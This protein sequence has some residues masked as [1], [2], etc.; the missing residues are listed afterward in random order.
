MEIVPEI[1]A[2][3]AWPI[4]ALVIACIFRRPITELLSR[5]RQIKAKGVELILDRLEKE[6]QLPV[7][8]RAELSGLSAHDIWAL[9]D[10]AT[11]RITAMPIEMKP[12]QRVAARTL[13][14]AG[15]LTL[16][17]EG[18]ARQVEV[19]PLG[20]RILEAAGSLL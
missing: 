2:A 18:A 6:G 8:A 12:A 16:R 13:L 5:V 15:L 14:D 1:L 10:F 7:G 17:G 19:T 9:N 20:Q 4:V 3:T 11:K